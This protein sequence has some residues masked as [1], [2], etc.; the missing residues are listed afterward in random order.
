MERMVPGIATRDGG[1]TAPRGV[2]PPLMSPSYI[3][4]HAI[5]EDRMISNGQP[6]SIAEWDG[7]DKL[8][9]EKKSIMSNPTNWLPAYPKGYT[10]F[11]THKLKVN[12]LPELDE[13]VC[14]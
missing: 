9:Q 7:S 14:D 3:A 12:I 4:R 11:K 1:V 2:G 8:G 10:S 5:N 6:D 13:T